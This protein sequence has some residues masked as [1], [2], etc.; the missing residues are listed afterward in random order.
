MALPKVYDWNRISATLRQM[1]A[2]FP[3]FL[4]NVVLIGGGACWF[5][6]EVLS[7]WNDPIFRVPDWTQ[8]EET[9][10]MS[11]DVDLIG[12]DEEEAT[13]LL[14]TPFDPETHTFHYQGLELDFLEE[15]LLLTRQNVV[16]NRRLVMLPEL[17][18]FVVEATLL[19]AENC[20]LLRAQA[21]PQDWLHR[22]LLVE[23]LKAEFCRELESPETLN[24]SRWVARARAAKTST[25]DFFARDKA[26]SDRL[27][28]A[29]SQLDPGL[30]KAVVH[31]AK[32]HLPGYSE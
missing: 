16:L 11:K 12:L 9:T 29:V 22:K 26:F 19:Y 2:K 3:G 7:Q 10:W 24:S 4:G 5:Y 32:P 15:G 25:L 23:F 6:R 14:K 18:F 13:A 21:R 30:H 31:W 27:S 17:T 20:A 28:R 1:E 8:E